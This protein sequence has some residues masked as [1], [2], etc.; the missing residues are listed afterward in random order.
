MRCNTYNKC[1][2][3][4]SPANETYNTISTSRHHQL[5]INPHSQ[6]GPNGFQCE[7]YW[8]VH[9]TIFMQTF[10]VLMC[11][12]VAS[13]WSPIR[14]TAIKIRISSVGLNCADSA[15]FLEVPEPLVDLEATLNF[16][17]N[18]APHN[19]LDSF[20]LLMRLFVPDT[21]WKAVLKIMVG[22]IT[23]YGEHRILLGLLNEKLMEKPKTMEVFMW[24]SLQACR[25][26]NARFLHM[27]W[28]IFNVLGLKFAFSTSYCLS[29]THLSS[30]KWFVSDR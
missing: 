3:Q 2:Q 24:V 30:S 26:C 19:L 11:V 13:L 7:P 25:F 22:F 20:T 15:S 8:T 27:T 23:V 12:I 16:W 21:C 1:E 4:V 17:S 9:Q 28:K 10:V 6:I 18:K 5:V 29:K 14:F